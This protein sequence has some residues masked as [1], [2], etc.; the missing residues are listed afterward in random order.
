MGRTEVFNALSGQGVSDRVLAHMVASYADPKL[1]LQYKGLI[2]AQ[3]IIAWIQCVLAALIGL[4]FSTRLGLVATLLITSFL[5][6]FAYLFIWG[7]KHNKAWA[8]NATILLSIVNLPKGLDKFGEAPMANSIGL[9]IG[10]ALIG[11]TW[12]VRSK[13]FPDMVFVGPQKVRGK[14]AFSS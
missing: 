9:V 1:C 14:Y 2:K 6:A 11:F 8:Y 13:V 3:I 7:F 12:Y 10:I 4:G 5:V